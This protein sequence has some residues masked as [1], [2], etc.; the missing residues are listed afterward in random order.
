MNNLSLKSIIRIITLISIP[1]GILTLMSLVNLV[2]PFMNGGYLPFVYSVIFFLIFVLPQII[3]YCYVKNVCDS[4][5]LIYGEIVEKI[6]ANL[7]LGGW[8]YKIRITGTNTI[9]TTQTSFKLAV[10]LEVNDKVSM[11][12]DIKNCEALIA[13]KIG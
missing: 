5:E 1:L 3:R 10:K 9:L 6:R 8:V 4:S 11:Y 12:Y 7:D 13:S 2:F